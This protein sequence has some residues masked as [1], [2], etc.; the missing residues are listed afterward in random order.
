MAGHVESLRDPPG[1]GSSSVSSF[2]FLGAN[3]LVW[4][5]ELSMENMST[6]DVMCFSC[7]VLWHVSI[8]QAKHPIRLIYV[9]K[10]AS[11]RT[12]QSHTFPS[13]IWVLVVVVVVAQTGKYGRIISPCFIT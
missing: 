3:V 4:K 10:F 12:A 5:H 1:R 11:C 13:M 8:R 7:F 9:K 2:L 6:I